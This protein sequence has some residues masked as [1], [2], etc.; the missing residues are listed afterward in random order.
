ML[1]KRRRRSQASQGRAWL[2]GCSRV[3][4]FVFGVHGPVLRFG[5]SDAVVT[6]MQGLGVG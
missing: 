5:G 6:P 3:H 2:R 1:I 4:V